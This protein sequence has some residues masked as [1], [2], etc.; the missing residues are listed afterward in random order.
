[1]I[2]NTIEFLFYDWGN[3]YDINSDKK[4]EDR[5]TTGIVVDAFTDISGVVSGRSGKTESKRMY[6]VQYS[7]F[8][9]HDNPLY[10]DIHS[11]QLC[12]IIKFANAMQNY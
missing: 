10:I 3:T 12:K 2:G 6:K 8:F 7:H 9:Q 4:R 1:M 5:I 11:W